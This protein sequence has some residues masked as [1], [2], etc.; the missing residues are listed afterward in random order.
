MATVSIIEIIKMN[1]RLV[2]QESIKDGIWFH[3]ERAKQKNTLQNEKVVQN[4]SIVVNVR[5]DFQST[6]IQLIDAHIYAN[7]KSNWL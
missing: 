7:S 1:A 5:S 3:S 2:K 6:L 4:H